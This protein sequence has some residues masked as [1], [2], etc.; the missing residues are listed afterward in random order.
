MSVLSQRELRLCILSLHV[1]LIQP[2][3]GALSVSRAQTSHTLL[4]DPNTLDKHGQPSMTMK[5]VPKDI[6][7]QLHGL[8]VRGMGARMQYIKVDYSRHVRVW[9][10]VILA[11]P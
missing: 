9:P 10:S 5:H 7:F 11:C 2:D 3:E 4:L 6:K 1:W 8:Q